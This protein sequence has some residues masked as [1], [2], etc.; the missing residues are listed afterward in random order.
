[1]VMAPIPIQTVQT[2]DSAPAQRTRSL[3][4]R[5]ASCEREDERIRLRDEIVALNLPIADQVASRYTGRGIDAEDLRQTARLGLVK[6]VLRFEPARG[7][8]FFS[9]AVPTIRGEVQRYFRDHGWTVRPPR[10]IQ[11]LRPRIQ[12]VTE[13]LTAEWGR[14][15]TPSEVAVHLKA[16]VG[17]VIE[18]L[19]VDG[20]FAPTSLDLPLATEPSMS[21][22]DTLADRGGDLGAAEA[23]TVLA[24]L[25]S[26]LPP[27][28]RDILWMRFGEGRSQG[29]IGRHVGVTQAQVSRLLART[30]AA[31]RRELGVR[32]R[33]RAG[34]A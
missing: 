28:E 15:P 20:C 2:A 30:I 29:E 9:F 31:L 34:V 4:L 26:A 21:L 7:H 1:M 27:R 14:A 25:V 5:L 13:L 8:D 16:S 32:E 19:T 6:A 3:L 18:A 24:P 22:A 17:D 33:P 11:E 23:R 10:R 12:Q